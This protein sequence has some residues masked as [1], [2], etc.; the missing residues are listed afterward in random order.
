MALTPLGPDYALTFG[1][2]L[3]TSISKALDQVYVYR[4][5]LLSSPYDSLHL[6]HVGLLIG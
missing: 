3:A 5:L 4:Y 6:S 1:E 2:T